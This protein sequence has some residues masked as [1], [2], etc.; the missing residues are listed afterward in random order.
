MNIHKKARVDCYRQE[1]V[2]R[3]TRSCIQ[4]PWAAPA[5]AQAILG[6]SSDCVS[7][8][9]LASSATE[10]GIS[11][12]TVTRVLHRLGWN[13]LSALKPTEQSDA[14]NANNAS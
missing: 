1:G 8:A 9:G 4:A 7:T 3:L 14:L 6:I 11:P 13:K 5:D 12:T 2:G 10:V